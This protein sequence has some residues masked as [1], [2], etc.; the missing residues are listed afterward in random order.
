MPPLL[1][2]ERFD[3]NAERNDGRAIDLSLSAADQA[4]LPPQFFTIAK[5]L[6][7]NYCYWRHLRETQQATQATFYLFA[8]EGMQQAANKAA[9]AGKPMEQPVLLMLETNLALATSSPLQ[10][11][12]KTTSSGSSSR[13]V[14]TVSIRPYRCCTSSSILEP[15]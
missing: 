2:P 11:P 8:K 5:Q 9:E 4:L 6:T 13:T 3:P 12:V 7:Q 14:R 1:S 10:G 15:S